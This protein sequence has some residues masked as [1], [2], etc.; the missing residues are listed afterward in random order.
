METEKRIAELT[1]EIAILKNNL[2]GAFQSAKDESDMHLDT[3]NQNTNEIQANYAYLAEIEAKVDKLADKMDEIHMKINPGSYLQNF[4]E[5]MLSKREQ[6][7]FM[8]IYTE[9]DRISLVS[10]AKKLGL[11]LEMCEGF[12]SRIKVKGI[13]ILK[14]LVDG[15]LFVSLDYDFKDIQARKNVLRIEM[16]ITRIID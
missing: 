12:L 6:E 15:K 5:I 4:E 9:E 10:L 1:Q 13:P 3:I 16:P 7:F 2:Q 14:Q 11:T 8:G